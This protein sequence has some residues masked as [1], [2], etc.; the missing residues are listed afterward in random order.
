MRTGTLIEIDRLPRFSLAGFKPVFVTVA[1]MRELTE[2]RLKGMQLSDEGAAAYRE[3]YLSERMDY[4]RGHITMEGG[5]FGRDGSVTFHYEANLCTADPLE[6]IGFTFRWEYGG[7]DHTK[8]VAVE[9]R[10][11]NLGLGSVYYFICPYSGTLCRKLYTDGNVLTG[12]RGFK[13][14]YSARNDSKRHR[15]IMALY[16]L[17]DTPYREPYRKYYY[18]G[19]L[20]PY[21][22]RMEGAYYKI[23]GKGG[24]QGILGAVTALLGEDE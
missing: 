3:R 12:R 15:E 1:K 22:L 5:Y 13:H 14:T 7:S 24:G 16:K 11:S 18:R 19:K 20:T 23:V 17:L 8:R 21:G 2:N 10:P 6:V 4:L 9:A